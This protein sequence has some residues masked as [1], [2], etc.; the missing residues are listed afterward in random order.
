MAAFGLFVLAVAGAAV[1][2]DLAWENPTTGQLTVFNQTVGGY[3]EG[4]LP[5]IAAGLGLVVALLLVASVN[6]TRDDGRAASSS[7]VCGRA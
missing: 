6:S 2:A 1:V 5:A 4:W 3:P 7:E